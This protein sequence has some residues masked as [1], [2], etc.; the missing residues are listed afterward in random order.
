APVVKATVAD[1]AP[2]VKA[3]VADNVV[4]DKEPV[5]E[6]S[7]GNVG[8]ASVKD[9]VNVYVLKGSLALVKD[10]VKA[11]VKDKV[12]VSVFKGNLAPVNDNVN[13]PVKDNVKEKSTGVVYKSK[14]A[15]SK[16][17]PKQEVI[18]TV[19]EL[20]K[21]PV[22]RSSNQKVKPKVKSKVDVRVSR[23]KETSV[24]RKRIL[25]KEDDRKKKLKGKSK[26]DDFE[27]ELEISDVDSSSD[28]VDRKQKK[29]K[30]KAG[31]KRKGS[32]SDSSSI[33]TENIKRLIKSDEESVPKK[34][35]KKKKKMTPE[36]ATHEEY[37]SSF[38]TFRARTTPSSLFSAIR[39]S[40]VDILSFFSG[41]GFSS[42]HNVSIDQPPSKLGRFVV[43]NFKPKTYMLSLD[44]GDKIEVTHSK[45]HEILG[46]PVGGSLLFDMDEREADH[47]FVRL[48][49]VNFLT[50][51]TNMMGKA[52]GLKGQICLDV[53]RRLLEDCVISDID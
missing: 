12:E 11:P 50:L 16:D 44:S 30:I 27:S 2:V 46:V 29:L 10:N 3:M 19:Q 51:F 39:N 22:L 48:W 5:K 6:K 25:S 14:S 43:S 21:V 23:S 41:I 34:V 36:E 40:R 1:K 9:K 20:S 4:A 37:L 47:E 8:K 38:L 24:K 52:A 35:K 53:V 13:A 28:E 26:K 15:L 17:K 32:G 18:P 33:D 42:L 31:L 45:I 7:A 49:V